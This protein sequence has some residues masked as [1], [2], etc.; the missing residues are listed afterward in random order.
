M[1]DLK[2][3]NSDDTEEYF[4]SCIK[5]ASV[6]LSVPTD[7]IRI[8]P[9]GINTFLIYAPSPI[10]LDEYTSLYLYCTQLQKQLSV[11]AKFYGYKQIK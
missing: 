6:I 11:S 10:N 4:R 9:G 7:R 2:T 5:R 8:A 1:A 3:D